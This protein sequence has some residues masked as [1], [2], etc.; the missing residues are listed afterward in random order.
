MMIIE[1]KTWPELFNH[2]KSGKKK[3]DVRLADFKAFKG[4]ILVLK[5]WDPR[6]KQY[7]GRQIKKK[8]GYVL[9]FDLSTF[10]QEQ[11]IKEKGLYVLQLE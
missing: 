10:G 5:E 7:T 6:T 3:F 2:I 1:K 11:E 4:D 8:I 9:K